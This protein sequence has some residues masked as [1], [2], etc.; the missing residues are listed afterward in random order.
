ME[1]PGA[2]AVPV[3]VRTS[4]R[5]LRLHRSWLRGSVAPVERHEA[6]GNE[7]EVTTRATNDLIQLA[8]RR[9]SASFWET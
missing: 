5:C 4:V 9:A 6:S 8:A 2:T 7:N 1:R 3:A